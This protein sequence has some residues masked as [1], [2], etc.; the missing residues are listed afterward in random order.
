MS[1]VLIKSIF[2]I[3]IIYLIGQIF[4]LRNLYQI[5][6][7]E[8]SSLALFLAIAVGTIFATLIYA[9]FINIYKSLQGGYYKDLAEIEIFTC[10]IQL[11]T[12]LMLIMFALGIY[13]VIMVVICLGYI[14]LILGLITYIKNRNKINI[15][16]ICWGIYTTLLMHLT[17]F[18]VYGW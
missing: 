2:I 6:D 1:F 13:K 9:T 11:V 12:N 4:M 5:Y 17:Y 8:I 10:I 15:A 18:V 14:L 7:E 3:S 16:N